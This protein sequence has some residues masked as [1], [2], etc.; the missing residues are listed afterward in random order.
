MDYRK[1]WGLLWAGFTVG[2]VTGVLAVFTEWEWLLLISS[3]FVLGGILQAAA[4]YRC[5]HCGA[6]LLGVR[7][8]IPACCPA[9][10]HTLK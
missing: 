8:Q 10:G 1:S 2:L 5:P 7:G 6:R 4:F 9:C 3:L